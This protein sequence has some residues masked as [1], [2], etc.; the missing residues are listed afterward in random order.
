MG[1]W[2]TFAWAGLCA[3]LGLLCA[4]AWLLPAELQIA[5]R[6]RSDHWQ[7]VPWTLWSASLVHFNA[8]HLSVNLLALLCFAILGQHLGSEPRDALALLIAWPLSTL[9]LLVWPEI[10]FFAGFSGV[11]HALAGTIIARGAMNLIALRSFS[12]IAFLLALMLL[13]KLIWES[14]WHAPLRMDASW[15]FGV[16]QAVHL[17]GFVCGFL[18]A[19]ALYAAR[20]FSTKAL[21][22]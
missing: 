8:A 3:A 22:E 6:W 13:A 7:A 17:T 9:T 11:N 18:A 1:D 19:C 15:G 21:V 16:V 2:R 12:A 10:Q 20:I 14:A 5:L 4:V